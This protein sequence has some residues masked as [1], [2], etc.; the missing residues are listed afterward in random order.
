[1]IQSIITNQVVSLPVST[2]SSSRHVVSTVQSLINTANNDTVLN[3]HRRGHLRHQDPVLLPSPASQYHSMSCLYFSFL[4]VS[5]SS[6]F[7]I[8]NKVLYLASDRKSFDFYRILIKHGST[9]DL[10]TSRVTEGPMDHASRVPIN[11]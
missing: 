4:I 6:N 5:F 9:N 10:H 7:A 2:T 8:S 11:S 3:R 1:M